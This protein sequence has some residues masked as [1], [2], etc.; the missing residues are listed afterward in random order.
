MAKLSSAAIAALRTA[1]NRE[2][3]NLCPIRGLR[4]AAEQ[5]LV[6]S[7]HRRGLVA[8]DRSDLCGDAPPSW[9]TPATDGHYYWGAP[10]ITLA[11]RE[12][13]AVAEESDR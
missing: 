9:L 13:L 5:A 2:R 4:A 8:Y 12:A 11:G 3:G 1:A 7:L 10:R 6:D